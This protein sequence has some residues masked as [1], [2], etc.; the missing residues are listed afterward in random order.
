MEQREAYTI[1]YAVLGMLARWGPRSGYDVKRHFDESLGYVWSATHSQ[2]YKELRRLA[3][4]GWAEMEREEQE[5][6]PDRKVYRVT[7]AGREALAQWLSQ[8]ADML[9]LHDELMLKMAFGALAPPGAL[10][11]VLR[12]G[13]VDHE[14]RLFQFYEEARLHGDPAQPETWQEPARADSLTDPYIGLTVHLALTFEEMYLRWLHETLSMVAPG[15]PHHK[16]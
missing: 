7:P 13:I 8:P 10:A 1:T 6:R 14:Q 11:E 3:D 12:A 16:I 15:E 5:S 2:I 9:Q 4:L